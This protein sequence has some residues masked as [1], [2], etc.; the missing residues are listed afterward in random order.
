MSRLSDDDELD[1]DGY[2]IEVPGRDYLLTYTV[3]M[4]HHR[5]LM[6]VS[7]LLAVLL[8][9]MQHPTRNT[10]QRYAAEVVESHALQKKRK[11]AKTSKPKKRATTPPSESEDDEVVVT[12]ISILTMADGIAT[13]PDG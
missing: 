4:A 5:I 8:Q 6:T 9:W 12:D 2:E 13:S 1:S 3:R 7:G 11:R 10:C